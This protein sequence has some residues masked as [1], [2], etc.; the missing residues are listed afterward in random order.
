MPPGFQSTDRPRWIASGLL[1]ALAGAGLMYAYTRQALPIRPSEPVV[2]VVAP[3]AAP[4]KNP[5]PQPE[6]LQKL[7]EPVAPASEPPPVAASAPQ[8]D[9]PEAS[10]DP[11]PPQFQVA[12]KINVNTA[13]AAELELLPG[14]GPVMAKSIVE[15][16]EKH[17]PF[18]SI[19]E[20]DRV[21]GIGARTL[22]RLAPLVTVDLPLPSR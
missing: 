5:A 11:A 8:P 6:P 16:R 14:V 7:F 21:K 22:E 12:G 1:G 18:K 19:V 15:Y 13:P 4:R 3:Q 17:G 20:L 2:T 9:E 10:A